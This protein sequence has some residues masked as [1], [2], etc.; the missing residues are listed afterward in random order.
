MVI[1]GN[2]CLI[3]RVYIQRSKYAMKNKGSKIADEIMRE[4]NREK[5]YKE[6]FERK[7]EL[8]EKYKEKE[9]KGK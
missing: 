8:E 9:G 1:N 2:I 6:Y 4:I 5:Y 3:H 7:K